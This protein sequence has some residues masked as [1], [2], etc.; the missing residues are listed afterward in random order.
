MPV[1]SRT[2][3]C[4]QC[5]NVL[6]E[7][8]SIPVEARIP[9]PKCGSTT[10]GF[11]VAVSSTV[12]LHSKLRLKARHAAGGRPY[13]EQTVGSDLHRK[14]GIWMRLERVLD[15]ASNR[16]RERVTNPKTGEIVHECDE[17]LSDHQGHG[18]AKGREPPRGDA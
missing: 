3:K 14:T 12:E 7:D 15:R 9:C 13:L 10:R 2:T 5:G 16:Y 17:P 18:S 8:P 11:A 6:P 1:Q 4:G